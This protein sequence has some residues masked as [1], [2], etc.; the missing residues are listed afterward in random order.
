VAR[1]WGEACYLELVDLG[2]R[3]AFIASARSLL[4]SDQANSPTASMF[5][6]P[7]FRPTLANPMIGGQ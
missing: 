3:V 4:A 2:Q 1:R 6:K 7:S 5:D